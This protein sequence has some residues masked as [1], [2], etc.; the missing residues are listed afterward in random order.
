[1]GGTWETNKDEVTS[2]FNFL[3]MTVTKYP[4]ITEETILKNKTYKSYWDSIVKETKTQSDNE[5][6]SETSSDDIS[7]YEFMNEKYEDNDKD[8]SETEEDEEAITKAL[9]ISLLEEENKVAKMK[10][11]RDDLSR[12]LEST[13]QEFIQISKE[14][15]LC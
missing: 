12:E 3:G 11:L 15:L 14:R 4:I 7:D 6:T 13:T 9:Q 1:M 5:D 8:S 2:D 10:D